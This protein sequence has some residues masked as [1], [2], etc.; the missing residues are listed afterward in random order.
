MPLSR[1]KVIPVNEV[2]LNNP[3]FIS[4]I[5]NEL[6]LHLNYFAIFFKITF[7]FK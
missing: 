3:D 4:Q 5:L 6:L 2:P 1:L 7:L